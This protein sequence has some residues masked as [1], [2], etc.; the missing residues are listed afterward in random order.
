MSMK[1]LKNIFNKFNRRTTSVLFIVSLA[2]LLT[3]SFAWYSANKED[4]DITGNVGDF[5]MSTVLYDEAGEKLYD[6]LM[7]KMMRV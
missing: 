6:V 1:I 2:V 7:M 3:I 5:K 4:I